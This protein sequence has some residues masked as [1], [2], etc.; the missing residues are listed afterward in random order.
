MTSQCVETSASPGDEE[1]GG[2]AR[3]GLHEPEGVQAEIHCRVVEVLCAQGVPEETA[4]LRR[5]SVAAAV[6]PALTSDRFGNRLFVSN[7][8]LSETW[9]VRD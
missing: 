8:Q 9:K 7:C 5:G 6:A 4:C 1:A 2:R 3:A